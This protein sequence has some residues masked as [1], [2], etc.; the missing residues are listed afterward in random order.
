MGFKRRKL[1]AE[2][3]SHGGS[4]SKQSSSRQSSSQ[5]ST[6]S[7]QP[8]ARLSSN[9]P[10]RSTPFFSAKTRQNRL[11]LKP[12]SSQRSGSRYHNEDV[13]RAG[14][15]EA[16]IL[17]RE[18]SDQMNEIVMAVDM[19]EKGTIGCSY[20]IAR[21]EKL[22]LMQDI[23]M[24]GLDIVDMLKMHA[25]PTLI[26]ISTRSDEKLEEHLSKEA[27]GIDRGEEASMFSTMLSIVMF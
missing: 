2:A 24:A 13:V 27:R 4:S 12:S 15:S 21:E 1:S 5:R 20:Y 7:P 23:K 6:S 22:Y 9:P 25:Q 17:A 3:P 10:A 18:D 16:D 19:R 8:F 11:S 14:E 26:L